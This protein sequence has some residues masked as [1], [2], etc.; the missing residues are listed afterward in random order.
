MS[1][2]I[3]ITLFLSCCLLPFSARAGNIPQLWSAETLLTRLNKPNLVIVDTRNALAYRKGHI[4]GAVHLDAGCSGPL[5]HQ[6]GKVPCSLRDPDE[7]VN[8]L[9]KKGLCPDLSVVVYG[10]RDAWGAEGRLFW[11]LK[12]LGFSKIALLDG[13]YDR[14]QHISG[15]TGA[16]FA[17]HM[18]ACK[19]SNMQHLAIDKLQ[20]AYLGATDL[21]SR[22]QK[23]NLIFLD[24][25]TRA[26]YEG[27]ILYREQRGGHLPGALHLHWQDLWNDN[28]TLKSREELRSRLTKA[29]LPLPEQAGGKLIV[30]YCTGGIRSGFAW[31]VLHWLGY[32]E[33]E[34]YDNGFWEWATLPELPVNQR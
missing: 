8:V 32:P 15:P 10:D 25:R 23:N 12:K 1:N 11:I 31:F 7:I 24:V 6:S 29:G 14:W 33:V 20:Q 17:N 22:H 19:A 30:P 9:R 18:E 27:E 13:G 26:E 5:V 34:N 16:L 28:Y 3:S 2:I 4:K 21:Q